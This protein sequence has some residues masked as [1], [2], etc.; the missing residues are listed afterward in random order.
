MG[1]VCTQVNYHSICPENFAQ[2]TEHVAE[3]LGEAVAG[4]AT[5]A[6]LSAVGGRAAPLVLLL[7]LLVHHIR[8]LRRVTLV[9]QKA[10][11]NL[12]S[13]QLPIAEV[14]FFGGKL[15]VRRQI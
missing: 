9:F 10:M 1:F 12:D 4:E 14:L 8:L 15:F 6:G 5:A 7:V 3:R 2:A 13:E 11:F